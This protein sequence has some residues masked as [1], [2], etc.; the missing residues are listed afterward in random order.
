MLSEKPVAENLQDA[1]ELIKWYHTKIDTKKVTWSVAENY[2]HLN[3]FNHAQAEVQKLGRVLNFRVQ[4]YGNVKLGS[5][6]YGMHI[7]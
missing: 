3:S 7:N 2:R 6:Y 1:I 5:R 4:K